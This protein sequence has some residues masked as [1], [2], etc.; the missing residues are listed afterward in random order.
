MF[1]AFSNQMNRVKKSLAAFTL[2]EILIT[3]AIIGVVAA[4][5][6]P[7]LMNRMNNMEYETGFKKS[8]SMLNPCFVSM[9]NDNGGVLKSSYA[10][11]N[12]FI[13]SVCTKAICT[14]VCH[15]TDAHECGHTVGDWYTLD[16]RPG[17]GDLSGGSGGA[18]FAN[19]MQ[20][21]VGALWSNCDGTKYLN[22]TCAQ[23]SVD[24]NGNKKPNKAG[25]D[26]FE[27]MLNI[28][29]KIVPQGMPGTDYPYI[30]NPTYCNPTSTAFAS[31]G[32]S[33]GGKILQEGG[34]NY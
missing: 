29:G 9:M 16:G 32:A 21:L 26:I 33:C 10:N 20:I 15:T 7:A 23:F 11:I 17:W 28:D 19:G 1:F 3:I 2:A 25:R 27:F 5:T 22:T 18:I 24:T 13:D 31:N 12:E 34:M 8:L 6:I 30:G 4:L 14:K